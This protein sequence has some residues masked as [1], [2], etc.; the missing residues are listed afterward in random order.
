MKRKIT[1]ILAADIASFSRL[2]AEDEDGTL[3]R[4]STHRDVF[5]DIVARSHGRVFNTAGDSIMCEFESP[6]DAVRAAI[7]IQEALRT[8]NLAFPP[9]RW[10]QFRIGIS[11][12][13]VVERDGD[14][15]GMAVNIAARL[16]HLAKPGGICISRAVHDAV[17]SR[18]SVPFIDLGERQMKN[19]PEPIHAFAVAWPGA[20]V[21]QHAS[22]LRRKPLLWLGSVA[23][24]ALVAVGSVL[25]IQRLAAPSPPL[26]VTKLRVE[27]QQDRAEPEGPPNRQAAVEPPNRQFAQ[28][29]SLSADPAEAFMQVVQGRG[30]VENPRS[31]AEFY[32]NALL[33]QAKGELDEAHRSYDALAR[34]GLD[35][36][37]PHLRFAALLRARDGRD[38][39]RAAYASLQKDAP[40]RAIALVHAM[41]FEGAERREKINA[42]IDAYP[43][44]APAYFVLAAEHSEE[45]VVGPQTLRDK[46]VQF[47]ALAEFL[48]VDREKRL[49]ALFLDHAVL[50]SWLD[51]A[52]QDH[53][54]L[55]AFLKTASLAPTVSFMRA[56]T[57][58]MASVSTPEAATAIGYRI[59]EGGEFRTTGSLQALDSRTGKPMPNPAFE[60][61]ADQRETTI[62]IRYADAS[63]RDI[64]PFPVSFNPRQALVRSQRDI[65]EQMPGAWLSLQG[66]LVYY[67]HL[68]SY[69]CAIAKARIGIDQGP[70][71]RELP[72]P[73]CNDRDPYAIAHRTELNLKLP[74]GARSV[75]V[76]LTYADGTQ[77][78]V[79]T[80]RRP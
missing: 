45:R 9:A 48:K 56:N 3:Q 1:A 60:L 35:L 63:G 7:D 32:A 51:K 11:I 41:Q 65:L 79:K 23:A 67:T 54:Q 55:D 68:V 34:M 28:A 26:T 69:R 47:A 46:Q 27:K 66:G 6:V 77:S 37:D 75:A 18:L 50:A 73:A 5:I 42:V 58:W 10:L 4:L 70:L 76:Q 30:L 13:D 80:F 8:R 14:L 33:F 62:F 52:G 72:L 57:G 39:A 40:T 29:L 44:F 71:D 15:L 36:V 49:S 43:D 31:A 59:G 20:D 22:G 2:V 21:F 53:A 16:E 17:V 61:P 64:G 24:A 78:E 74:G 19:I 38:A 25:A 12:G